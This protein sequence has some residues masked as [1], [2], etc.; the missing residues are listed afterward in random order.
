MRYFIISNTW[1]LIP[2]PWKLLSWEI[3]S[4]A[5]R[6]NRQNIWIH[7]PKLWLIINHSNNWISQGIFLVY[8]ALYRYSKPCNR[9]A[10]WNISNSRNVGLM[11]S[12]WKK[13]RN[14]WRKTKY[15]TA[16]IY[17]ITTSMTEVDG[18]C[19]VSSP[20]TIGLVN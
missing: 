4:I 17:Q 14:T 11:I 9:I 19:S 3:P 5:H 15:Y 7:Y 16:S 1:F 8:R 20:K 13:L 12:V 2:I 18:R 6:N 10:Y